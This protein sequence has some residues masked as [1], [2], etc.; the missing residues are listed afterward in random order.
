MP[1]GDPCLAGGNHIGG[2]LIPCLAALYPGMYSKGSIPEPLRR[3][4]IAPLKTPDKGPRLHADT[5]P[6]PLLNVVM[7]ILQ[8][9]S[10]RR[11][12]PAAEPMLHPSRYAYQRARGAENQLISL[13]AGVHRF[14]LR[15]Q[16]VYVVS[17]LVAEASDT[18]SHWRLVEILDEL[19]VGSYA[20]RLRP[21]WIRG[22]TFVLKHR[23]P[24]GVS[25]EKELL[26]QRDCPKVGPFPLA[27]GRCSS[28]ACAESK[29]RDVRRVAIASK[30][31]RI[32]SLR[33]MRQLKELRQRGTFSGGGRETPCRMFETRCAPGAWIFRTRR[34]TTSGFAK[35]FCQ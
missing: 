23:T 25:M 26:S 34:P 6:I 13:M 2:T 32:L 15:G 16:N 11:M 8:G 20:R 9:V 14:L 10:Y 3:V 33:M 18:A 29:T 28:M 30:S 35:S 19:G 27:S 1:G 24:E 7:E 17:H 4:Q 22:R 21:H 31:T 12:L 5:R